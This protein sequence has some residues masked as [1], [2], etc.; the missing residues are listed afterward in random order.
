MLEKFASVALTKTPVQA[1][2]DQIIAESEKAD[3][4]EGEKDGESEEEVPDEL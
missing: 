4:Q 1:I 2:I 3:A